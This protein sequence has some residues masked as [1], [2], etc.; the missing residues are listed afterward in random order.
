MIPSALPA[1]D[2]LPPVERP[3]GHSARTAV[4]EG[5]YSPWIRRAALF[6][7][8]RNPRLPPDH[9]G[10][11]PCLDVHPKAKCSRR[12]RRHNRVTRRGHSQAVSAVTA[13]KSPD[14][15]SAARRGRLLTGRFNL[16]SRRLLLRDH[17]KRLP[18]DGRSSLLSVPDPLLVDKRSSENAMK[19]R[20]DSKSASQNTAPAPR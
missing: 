12:N 9:V 1:L 20:R 6:S 17:R 15:S 14:H 11:F 7:G 8:Q 3:A 5:R 18:A 4:R 13:G 2:R 10:Q 16:Q 19:S